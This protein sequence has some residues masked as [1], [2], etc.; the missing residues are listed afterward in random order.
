MGEEG[1]YKANA[2]LKRFKRRLLGQ[3]KTSKQSYLFQIFFFFFFFSDR[4]TVTFH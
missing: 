3:D 2:T 4:Y 1:D